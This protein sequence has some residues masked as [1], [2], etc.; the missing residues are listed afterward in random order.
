MTWTLENLH[1]CHILQ[2][3]VLCLLDIYIALTEGEQLCVHRRAFKCKDSHNG[4]LFLHVNQFR[5]HTNKKTHS[6][7]RA[8]SHLSSHTI[9][10]ESVMI[11]VSL[12]FVLAASCETKTDDN[13][14]VAALPH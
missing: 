12:I 14:S 7:T 11:S 6:H 2:V 10:S 5:R 13:Y 4:A 1:R 8:L 9:Q 3:V